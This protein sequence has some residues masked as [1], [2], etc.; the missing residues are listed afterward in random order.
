ML[1]EDDAAYQ[2]DYYLLQEDDT[3]GDKSEETSSKTGTPTPSDE[4]AGGQWWGRAPYMQGRPGENGCTRPLSN[5]YE[6]T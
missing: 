3:T 1:Q 5:A 4:P 2:Q 6:R